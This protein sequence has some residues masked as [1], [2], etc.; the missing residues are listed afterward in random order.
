MVEID[1]FETQRDVGIDVVTELS[2][3]GYEGAE[4]HGEQRQGHVSGPTPAPSGA[5]STGNLPLELTS[6]VNRRLEL[7][8]IKKLLTTSRLVTLTGMGGVGKSRLALR[9]AHQISGDF[10]D[11]VWL[12]E[13]GELRDATLLADVAAAALGV[14]N[15]GTGSTLDVLMEFLAARDLLL[16]LDNCEH[17]IEE[18]AGLADPLLR[19]CPGLRILATSRE[20]L[21]I[22]GESVFAVPALSFPAPADEPTPWTAARYDALTLFAERAAAAVH[23]FEI[24]D[25]TR[26]SVARICARLDGL[27]LAIELAAARLRTMSPEQILSRL[28]DRYAL[29]TRGNRGAP[30]RQ[31]TLRWC[32]AWSYDLCTPVEQLLWNQLSAFAGG[33]ELDAAEYVC[34]PDI[35]D[36]T[37][38]NALSALVEKSILIRDEADG[39]VRFRMLET[40]QEYGR[41]KAAETGGY[42]E[43]CRRHRQWCERLAARAQDEWVG[44]HQLQWVARLERELPNLRKALEFSLTETGDSALRITTALYSF[45]MTRGRLREGRPWYERALDHTAGRQ[46]SD[47]ANALHKSIE[48]AL[49]Q[50][51]T[52]AVADIVT[53]LKS[54]ARHTRE[55]LVDALL[56]HAEANIRLVTGDAD[57]AHWIAVLTETADSYEAMGNLMLELEARISIGWAYALTGDV[58]HALTNF[59]KVLA[60]AES[61][62]ET[63]FRSWGQWGA[64]FSLWRSGDSERAIQLLQQGIRSARLGADPLVT[65][66]CSEV[67]AWISAERNNFRRAAALMG[68]ADSLASIAGGSAFMLP[69]LLCYREECAG[70][71]RK[72]LGDS[73]FEAARQ[74]GTAMSF[75]AAASFAL[76]E[77]PDQHESAAQSTGE[78]TKREC[79]VAGLVARG[80][81]NKQIAAQLA[82]SL[83]T[84][85]AHVEHIL[86]KLG[87]A[88]RSQIA[89]WASKQDETCVDKAT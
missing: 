46:T 85:K 37:L 17:L 16:I 47:R 84:A 75:D 22:G 28:D 14:R 15:R 64:G 33:F 8:A 83:R 11:G 62:E 57:P 77:Q 30:I 1:P 61:V 66:A 65:G 32:I 69:G 24:T 39:T 73:A 43:S 80:F 2:A 27:P 19:S 68:A 89:S 71:S 51:D 55:P 5:G 36:A 26:L 23:G 87:F 25:D 29:L 59:Q 18:V 50:G 20:A 58:E 79:Q 10:A 78:L 63:V 13:L 76:G 31:Q 21:S 4:I 82:I 9:L 88:S 7:A 41:D 35:P 48:M 12:V 3:A 45:W 42:T 70:S 40:V 72:A 34:G 49:A 53:E 86:T 6:F 54:V 67:L 74:E 44:P 60:T 38:M 52:A 56:A 81:T